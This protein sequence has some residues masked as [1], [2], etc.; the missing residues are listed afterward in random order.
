MGMFDSLFVDC[1]KCDG[2]IEF[3]SKAGECALSSFTIEDVG[4]RS[5]EVA[6]DLNGQSEACNKCGHVL[7]IGA[8]VLAFVYVKG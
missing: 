3:Q 1:P 5:P 4:R 7:T 6:M 8:Q 2:H